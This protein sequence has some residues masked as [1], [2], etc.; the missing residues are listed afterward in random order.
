MT[1]Q[2]LILSIIAVSIILSI[3]VA[4]ERIGPT[5]DLF[6]LYE[7]KDIMTGGGF[8]MIAGVD[9]AASADTSEDVLRANGFEL[10]CIVSS[11]IDWTAVNEFMDEFYAAEDAG[12]TSRLSPD[13]DASGVVDAN[14]LI[15]VLGEWGDA[16][17]AGEVSKADLN[18]DGFVDVLDLFELLA[19]WSDGE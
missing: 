12:E 1:R 5:A 3:A 17:S 15:A 19:A 9:F 4:D 2:L 11:N 10:R 16:E 7:G 6:E 14:D 8:E 18:G 13:I